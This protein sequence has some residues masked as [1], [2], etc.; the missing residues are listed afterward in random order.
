MVLGGFAL[1][2]FVH[3]QSFTWFVDLIEAELEAPNRFRLGCSRIASLKQWNPLLQLASSSCIVM[4]TQPY[5]NFQLRN[6]LWLGVA[7]SQEQSRTSYLLNSY[8]GIFDK[9][10]NFHCKCLGWRQDTPLA[11]LAQV[12]YTTS[13]VHHDD[14]VTRASLYNAKC[15]GMLC[16]KAGWGN[17]VKCQTLGI[18]WTKEIC[19]KFKDIEFSEMALNNFLNPKTRYTPVN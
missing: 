3:L 17:E 7:L 9:L 2:I 6:I 15:L 19:V 8:E 4:A 10:C 16:W 5:V 11:S 1:L 13:V 12:P 14:F 18:D